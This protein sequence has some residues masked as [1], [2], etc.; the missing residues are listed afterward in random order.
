[1][2]LVTTIE[3]I[4]GDTGIRV[5]VA[6]KILYATRM[7]VLTVVPV[8]GT[9]NAQIT[10]PAAVSPSLAVLHASFVLNLLRICSGGL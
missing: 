7:A 1:M 2:K 3:L 6:V 9:L 5:V 10:M 4:V 8:K